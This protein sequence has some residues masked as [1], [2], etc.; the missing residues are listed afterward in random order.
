MKRLTLAILPLAA[1]VWFAGWA[2]AETDK[3]AG[4][5]GAAQHTAGSTPAPRAPDVAGVVKGYRGATI[6]LGGHRLLFVKKG[7][8]L[9]VMV[10]F[11]AQMKNNVKE[12]VT[13]TILQNVLVVDIYKPANVSDLGAIEILLNPN[14]AQYAMLSLS[15]GEVNIVVRAPGDFEMHPME[16][17]GFRKLFR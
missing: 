14:E 13:A 10:T 3:P 5:D 16:M 12:K 8:R 6:P 2:A 1:T 9:D 17:A 7:D 4:T 15:Q 11:D